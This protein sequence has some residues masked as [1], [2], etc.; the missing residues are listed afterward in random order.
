[1]RFV[2]DMGLAPSDGSTY[3]VSGSITDTGWHLHLFKRHFRAVVSEGYISQVKL[4]CAKNY[5][6]FAFD[7]TLQYEINS[8]DGD[9]AIALDGAPGTQ[10]KLTQ[11]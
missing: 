5:R 8:K 7:P 11:F 6:Y 3:E 2:F 9:C 1:M 4:R 10:F